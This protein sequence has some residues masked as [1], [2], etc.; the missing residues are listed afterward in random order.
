MVWMMFRYRKNR[1]SEQAMPTS[2]YDGTSMPRTAYVSKQHPPSK[3]YGYSTSAAGTIY[4]DPLTQS[5]F[6]STNEHLTGS[7]LVP[8]T[9]L[10]RQN[11]PAPEKSTAGSIV[12][13]WI[14]EEDIYRYR[15]GPGLAANVTGSDAGTGNGD[16]E[17]SSK[18]DVRNG[19]V[20]SSALSLNTAEHI[21]EIP[22]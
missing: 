16:I 8:K 9:C 20:D 15:T 5:T 22:G 17:S 10:H 4:N 14:Q 3:S 11:G 18:P 1:W 21:Y 12:D 7:C 19:Y 6:L 2:I 13:Q